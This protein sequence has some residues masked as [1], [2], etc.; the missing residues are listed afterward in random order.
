MTIVYLVDCE[1][2]ARN[3]SG[4]GDAFSCQA[5]PMMPHEKHAIFYRLLFEFN[6]SRSPGKNALY[7]I[8]D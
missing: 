4:G 8:G 6:R 5:H 1:Y 3:F 2:M 7:G